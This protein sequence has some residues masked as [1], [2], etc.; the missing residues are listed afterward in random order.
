[1]L[2]VTDC[3]NCHFEVQSESKPSFIKTVH[4]TITCIN[5]SYTELFHLLI[6]KNINPWKNQ[7]SSFKYDN[8]SSVTPVFE[9]HRNFKESAVQAFKDA[10]VNQELPS[11]NQFYPIPYVYGVP[12][13]KESLTPQ[14]DQHKHLLLV[15]DQSE[16]H[17]TMCDL[18]R[19]SNT[20]QSLVIATTAISKKLDKSK[21]KSLIDIIKEIL[22]KEEFEVQKDVLNKFSTFMCDEDF[23]VLIWIICLK[24]EIMLDIYE[25]FI[26]TFEERIGLVVDSNFS[27]SVERLSSLV[28]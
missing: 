9:I 23:V 10:L 13:L 12:Y 14:Q 11:F 22:P 15:L 5:F 24:E 27:N 3:G 18:C 21:L 20:S 26:N 6:Y 16:D 1:M 17:Q 28:T 8:L 2:T 19:L 7:W 25:R 4:T